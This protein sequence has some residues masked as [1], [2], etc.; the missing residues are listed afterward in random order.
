MQSDESGPAG[1]LRAE[2]ALAPRA[3]Q[4]GV[5]AALRLTPESPDDFRVVLSFRQQDGEMHETS[6]KPVEASM[7]VSE[8]AHVLAEGDLRT[9]GLDSD[10]PG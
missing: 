2:D 8:V 1:K 7:L 6:L 10:P 4:G 9:A 5:S 3:A